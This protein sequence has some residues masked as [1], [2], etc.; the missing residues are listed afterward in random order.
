ML[1]RLRKDNP[2]KRTHLVPLM[3]GLRYA[4]IMSV[5]VAGGL[6]AAAQQASAPPA[7]GGEAKTEATPAPA[8]QGSQPAAAPQPDQSPPPPAQVPSEVAR[9]EEFGRPET[10][11][12][13]KLSGRQQV[14]IRRLLGEFR[15]KVE[16]ADTA[17][18]V[19]LAREFLPRVLAVLT[20]EQRRAYEEGRPVPRLRFQFR[21]QRWEHVLEWLAE[22]AG[23]SL[24]LDAP[25]PGT[26]NYTDTR[27]YTPTEA[28]DL[29]NS[30]L[31]TKGYALIRRDQM[32]ILVSLKGGIPEGLVP[33][34]TAEE[35]QRMGAYDLVTVSFSVG[36]R[37][38][39]Q[40]AEAIRPLLGPYGRVLPIPATRQV[41]VT[42]RAG[43]MA[44]VDKVIQALPEPSPPRQEP[45]P[46]E[47]E[48]Q[49]LRIY[50][51][52]KVDPSALLNI[53]R[54]LYPAARIVHDTKLNQLNV[55]AT[56]S[57]HNGI[58]TVIKK[59]ESPEAPERMPRLEVYPLP[60][61]TNVSDLVNNLQFVAPGAKIRGDEDAQRVIVWG[62]P[63]EQALIAEAL[64]KLQ[65]QPGALGTPQVET[66]RLRRSDA[67]MVAY[68]LEKLVPKA[69]VSYDY[70]G[71]N[72]VVY[73]TAED[74]AVVRSIIEEIEPQAVQS[75]DIEVRVYTLRRV[76]PSSL[77]EMLQETLPA[78]K[79]AADDASRRLTVV[80][81]AS[82]QA[83]VE[84]AVKEADAPAEGEA[85]AKLRTYS[86]PQAFGDSASTQVLI[87]FLQQLFPQAKFTPDT[88]RG[89]LVVYATDE[90]QKSIEEILAEW[91]QGA[92]PMEGS[93]EVYSVTPEERSRLQAL[94]TN[95]ASELPSLRVLP[96]GAPGTI[97]VWARPHEHEL[98][99]QILAQLREAEGIIGSR[100]LRAYPLSVI[101]LSA[102][103][104][105]VQKLFP[106]V[107]VVVDQAGRRLLVWAL[108]EEHEAIARTLK[109][110][111]AP[112]PQETQP[113]F[114]I[115]PIRGTNAASVLSTLQQL[116]PGARLVVDASGR[117]IIAWASPAEHAK[118]QA[119]LAELSQGQTAETAPYLVVYPLGGLNATQVLTLLQSLVPD[120]QLSVDNQSGSILAVAVATDHETIRA[121]LDR[122]T[123][124][125]RSLG[126]TEIRY[127]PYQ[128]PPSSG[129]LEILA[130]LA[131]TAQVTVDKENRRLIVVASPDDH[132]L[133]EQT[134]RDYEQKTPAVSDRQLVVY[135]LSPVE[136]KRLEA[137]LP[138]LQKQLPDLQLLPETVP[139]EVAVWARPE[140]HRLLS[141]IVAQ[142]RKPAELDRPF[143]LIAHGV[144]SADPKSVVEML[145]KLFPD[146]Q[147]VL[148]AR[149]RRVLI[150]APASAEQQI[151]QIL[152][153]L[154]TGAPGQ[155]QEQLRVY[156]VIKSDLQVALQVLRERLPDLRITPDSRANTLLV[157]GTEQDHQEVA[158]L[159]EQ[160]DSAVDEKHRPRLEIYPAGGYD[161]TALSTLLR[162]LVPDARLAVDPKTGG[163]AV[164]ARPEDH[165]LVRKTLEELSR[166]DLGG[167]PE[168]RTYTVA[169]G[170]SVWGVINILSTVFPTIRVTIGTQ[171]NQILVWARPEEHEQVAKVVAE[172]GKE[173]PPETAPRLEVYTLVG[174]NAAEAGRILRFFAPEAVF[175]TG[176]DP[177]QLLVWARPADHQ[178]I[179]EAL[180]QWAEA[181]RK[182]ETL[183]ELAVFNLKYLSAYS[184]VQALRGVVPEAQLSVGASDRQLIV[185]ARSGQLERVQA[186]LEKLDVPT[187]T[188]GELRVYTLEG[189]STMR[190]FYATRLLREA[191]PEAT[192]ALGADP[193]QLLVWATPE[194]HEKVRALVDTLFQR[195]PPEKAPRVEVYRLKA[196]TATTAS[197]VLR[198]AVPEAN[199]TVDSADPY[200]L[201]VWAA[202]QEHELIA[203]I[204][205]QI[206]LPDQAAEEYV[207]RSYTVE[208]VSS[209]YAIQ[210]LGRMFP[211]AQFVPT[212]DPQQVI[213]W[214]KPEEHEKIRQALAELAPSGEEKP[215]LVTYDLQT[216]DARTA[217]SLIQTVAPGAKVTASSDG[218]KLLVYARPGE[219]GRIAEVLKAADVP[220]EGPALRMEVYPVRG[221]GNA[222]TVMMLLRE[223]FP[224]AKFS[225]GANLQQLVVYASPADHAQIAQALER[226]AELTRGEQPEVV[227]YDVGTADA[228]RLAS[229]LETAFPGSRFVAGSEPGKLIAWAPRSDHQLIA[230]AIEKLR[231]ETWGAE[232]RILSVY[233]LRRTDA[234]TLL[235]VLTPVLQGNAQF[236]VDSSRNSLVV[237]ADRRYHEAIRQAIEQYLSATDRVGELE[238]RVYRFRYADPSAAMTVVRSLAPDAQVAYD[239]ANQ[240]LVISA[241]PED[242]RKI[243]LALLQLDRSDV[244]GT[245]P[246]LRAY[247]VEGVDPSQAYSNLR[248]M[249]RYDPS[250]Q[251][252]LDDSSGSVFA[253]APEGKHEQIARVLEEMQLVARQGGGVVVQTYSLR[254]TDPQAALSLVRNLAQQRGF[255]ADASLDSRSNSLVVIARAEHHRVIAE[256]LEQIRGEE[257][258]LEI[259]QL[260][261]LDPYSAQSAIRQLFADE[262]H[263]PQV[264]IDYSAQQLIIQATAEQHRRIRELLG[265]MGET[266][267]AVVSALSGGSPRV[268]PFEGNP[269]EALREIER[270]WSQLRPNPL[271]IIVTQPGGRSQAPQTERIGAPPE[272]NPAP[273]PSTSN[274]AAP[275]GGNSS[276]GAPQNNSSQ[277]TRDKTAAKEGCG[278]LRSNA[279]SRLGKDVVV[280]T[281]GTG[282]GGRFFWQ[283]AVIPW[284]GEGTS[285]EASAPSNDSGD[286]SPATP[287]QTPAPKDDVSGGADDRSTAGS[288]PQEATSGRSAE[289]SLGRSLEVPDTGGTQQQSATAPTASQAG[290]RTD[291]ASIRGEEGNSA[292]PAAAEVQEEKPVDRSQVATAP[293]GQPPSPPPVY[294]L[295]QDGAVT[296]VSEDPEAAAE[297]ESLLRTFSARATPSPRTI[298]VYE[299]RHANASTVAEIIEDFLRRSNWGFRRA[300]GGLVIIPD[301]RQNTLLVQGTRS[302]RAVIE[303]LLRVLDTPQ[304]PEAV[305][306][307]QPR[308]IPLRNMDAS[309]AE[310]V[311]RNVFR[312][313]FTPPQPRYTPWGT[314][315]QPTPGVLTPQ[316]AIDQTTNSLIITGPVAV[317]EQIA[318]FVERLDKLAAEDPSRQLMIIPLKKLNAAE[319]ERAVRELVP[320]S[321]W[322]R[323]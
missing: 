323:Y 226:L 98:V 32:L 210:L 315:R 48:R 107:Q 124:A 38:A 267:L 281:Q 185:L 20:P 74:Q 317:V 69:R 268:I 266:R 293:G 283:L 164:L 63:A 243:E 53:L 254:N 278:P 273:K 89:Q 15:S 73:A 280:C 108:P 208:G 274:Q 64:Q 291:A 294:V 149:A 17:A 247:S 179:R 82:L 117:K 314:Q 88:R 152:E 95:L 269:A 14:E 216:L 1:E 33:W 264:D 298:T 118:I 167:T 253:L 233:P 93:L 319:V 259:L 249:F 305:R 171:P 158:K 306:A 62:T 252:S 68:I 102:A 169:G 155:W 44:T 302:D 224:Q 288:G 146:A 205:E 289:Q 65:E 300:L 105:T 8:P 235:Q 309:R 188:P 139:G 60:Q 103:Q 236:V 223:V 178:K 116:V 172:L 12:R 150:W 120:A 279:G 228:T 304:L 308:I 81:P 28:I 83:Q 193:S 97:A 176:P 215:S 57:Q 321:Y 270:V 41:V 142:L 263:P 297:L 135:Q 24:V 72:L 211:A 56:P 94:L 157:W 37:D 313:V 58:E 261:E 96:D 301:D 151:R 290:G 13:L 54:E 285:A 153:E 34:V 217:S 175:T 101:E 121:V 238:P 3:R 166:K 239:W 299:L 6:W 35:A 265:K 145:Q 26:F 295:V 257:R 180:A 160:L 219:H 147:V 22:Q 207:A 161:M 234:Q 113:R 311:V 5:L 194:I 212:M 256:A 148:D 141:E 165:E 245:R 154:D 126:G 99:R 248:Q 260:E 225:I 110:V 134:L 114:E 111:D 133:I 16:G 51:L 144:R 76:K 303:D 92:R 104:E 11:D 192:F 231:A 209:Y 229:M 45:P 251:L 182:P 25:P 168:A 27:E 250:V 262:A 2:G 222:Y 206:D 183:P 137:L 50:P 296:V 191:V 43:L 272:D 84:K 123:E 198:A 122:L 220:G 307:N 282:G 47:P 127:Y 244:G 271:R 213:A 189:M 195:P 275:P 184:A 21:F 174:T 237:W 36:R 277:D 318:E 71:R 128:V 29:V 39:S 204:L 66:Y 125:R 173:E 100:S 170:G 59:L 131:P 119:A 106:Q 31:L 30:V 90:E 109:E 201:T 4:A 286:N 162:T 242:H 112:A 140:E 276:T 312:V 258:Q 46:R 130:K 87:N 203:R 23:L 143:V 255:R 177:Q 49:E 202:P 187:Q 196:V 40:V 91:T 55:L 246:V 214:A 159:L 218:R 316:L 9:L 232:N 85:E 86:L 67:R 230:Q 227:V 132:R 129:L 200:K 186:A 287:L 181:V 240:A 322:R 190:A 79:F 18:Q 52:G 163:L 199:L 136:R 19:Q 42:D 241:L 80:A 284:V 320:R 292:K 221:V 75:G 70:Y 10:A 61:G 138:Q 197:Q 310:E 77:V 7:P 115:Y 78:A 156:P